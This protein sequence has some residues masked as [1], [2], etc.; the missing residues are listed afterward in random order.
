MKVKF[1][2]AW[3][4]RNPAFARMPWDHLYRSHL[5]LIVDSEAMGYDYAWLTEHH[6]ST[7]AIRHRCCR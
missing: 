3:P 5:D 7:M 6:S 4:F 2:F 1:G